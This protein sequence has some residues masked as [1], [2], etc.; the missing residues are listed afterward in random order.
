[1]Q[2]EFQPA[3]CRNGDTDFRANVS[4]TNLCSTRT[5]NF[6]SLVFYYCPAYLDHLTSIW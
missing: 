5:N 4:A 3:E 6:T 2:K 1:M